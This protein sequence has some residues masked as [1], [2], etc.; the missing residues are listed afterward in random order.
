[1][2]GHQLSRLREHQ[3]RTLSI[4]CL[5]ASPRRPPSSQ[6][7]RGDAWLEV[8]AVAVAGPRRLKGEVQK[9]RG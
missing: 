9:V 3:R 1:M 5:G 4:R 7:R 2:H 6:T 8:L